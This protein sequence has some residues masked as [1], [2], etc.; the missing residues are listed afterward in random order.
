MR[1]KN[2][3][4]KNKVISVLVILI[5][6]IL[7]AFAS[8]Q[9]YLYFN[10]LIGNDLV[11]KLATNQADFNL[12]YGQEKDLVF[13]LRGIANPLCK[14]EC[15]SV[16]YD[17]SSD[18]ELRRETFSISPGI[19]KDIRENIKEGRYGKG[20]DIYRFSV[21]CHNNPGVFCHTES[22]NVTRNILLTANY[23]LNDEEKEKI[24]SKRQE[25]ENLKIKIEEI[26]FS[27]SYFDSESERISN[28]LEVENYN[29]R[30]SNVFRDI[31]L[32]EEKIEEMKKMWEMQDFDSLEKENI[33]EYRSNLENSF[34][35]MNK[36]FYSAIEEYNSLVDTLK[37]IATNLEKFRGMRMD[38]ENAE[39]LDEQ[40]LFFNS[41]IKNVSEQ[42]TA[43]EKDLA[44]SKLV[45]IDLNFREGEG[46][47]LTM[48]K[49]E[50][51]FNLEKIYPYEQ[52]EFSYSFSLPDIKEKCC[53]YNKCDFCGESNENYPVIF[54][55]G[56]DFNR[57]VSA[58]YSL[59]AFSYFQEKL[60]K[61]RKVLDAGEFYL[62]TKI[63]DGRLS[64][65]NK[66]LSLRGSFYFDV[67]EEENKIVEIQTKTESIDNYAIRL[68]D[69]IDGVKRETGKDKVIIVAYSMG[70]L[71]SRRYIQ[72][73][74]EESVDRLVLIA[75]PNKGVVSEVRNYCGYFGAELECKDLDSKSL[76]LNKLNRG[77]QPAIPVY[78]IFGTGCSMK[79]DG[80]NEKKGDGIV[81][82]ENAILEN[83]KN[84]GI[85]GSCSGIN[86]LHNEIL[87]EKY[88]SVYEE[89]AEILA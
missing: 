81:L 68:R 6:V 31:N 52:E 61:D 59:N 56:H 20:Q 12:L 41:I 55:H 14:I 69:L 35:V 58:D 82:E 51:D 70:G 78:N 15:E 18:K 4:K 83:A 62:S 30:K 10:Y 43:R 44:A 72:L 42:K 9:A 65:I 74:G 23:D 73:F 7:I 8:I 5:L 16:F 63:E 29:E 54:I 75:V 48:A 89:L 36:S 76:F 17:L 19:N 57:G 27:V 67:F 33:Q 1:I 87:S 34:E 80:G 64:K 86:L 2:W 37:E 28:I 40:M 25:M 85:E 88:P 32:S 46:E 13:S 66:K 11:L 26:K 71:V 39:R 22:K 21:K 47:N 53:L 38:V 79:D 77:K 50:I 45:G 49:E 60:D 24:N 84:M 3:V